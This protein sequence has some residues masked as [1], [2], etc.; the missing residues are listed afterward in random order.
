MGDHFTFSTDLG[1][2]DC[3]GTPAGSGGYQQLVQNAIEIDM[4]GRRIKVAGLEDLIRM[5]RAA[6]RPRDLAEAEIL[7]AL[8]DVTDGETAT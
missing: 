1:D 5:K 2:F 4:W 6:G 8:R 3:L 7:G